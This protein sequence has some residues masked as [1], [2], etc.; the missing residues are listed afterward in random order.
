MSDANWRIPSPW[1]CEPV[2]VIGGGPSVALQRPARLEGRNVIVINSSYEVAPFAQYL[3]FGDN[4]W[5]VEHQD[6]PAFVAFREKATIVTVSDPASGFYLKKLNRTIPNKAETGLSTD[7]VSL[8]SQRT[9]FHGAINL[10]AM[11]GA[12]QIILLG[13]DGKRSPEG[14]SH[15]HRPHKWPTKPG[16]ITWEYQKTQLRHTVAPLAAMGVRVYNTNPNSSFDFW[17]F[18]PLERFL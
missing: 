7:R 5:H 3:F 12:T 11:L 10:A 17:P 9:S 2:F 4:R 15:H 16:I 13:L 14:V 8:S 1:K 6:R 18:E